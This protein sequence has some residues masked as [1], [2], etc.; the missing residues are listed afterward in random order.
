MVEV[1]NVSVNVPGKSC[2]FVL[3]EI[4]NYFGVSATNSSVFRDEVNFRESKK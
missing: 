2:I 4:K 3:D 1:V